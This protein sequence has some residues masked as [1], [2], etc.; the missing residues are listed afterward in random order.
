MFLF[1]FVDFCV[2]FCG[3]GR[4]RETRFVFIRIAPQVAC[5]RTSHTQIATSLLQSLFWTRLIDV[6]SLALLNRNVR[7]GIL[8]LNCARRLLAGWAYFLVVDLCKRLLA[9]WA[10]FLVVDMC[11]VFVRFQV[12]SFLFFF[13]CGRRRG[14]WHGY[15]SGGWDGDVALARKTTRTEAEKSDEDDPKP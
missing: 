9:G 2:R 7:G 6:A 14:Q 3:G 12:L 5:R 15:L 8:A 1:W 10:Y 11:F 13:G 4:R